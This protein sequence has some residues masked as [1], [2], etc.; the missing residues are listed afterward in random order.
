MG[1]NICFCVYVCVGESVILPKEAKKYSS[2]QPNALLKMTDGEK[3][4]SSRTETSSNLH[5]PFVGVLLL[6]QE[7][8]FLM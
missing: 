1:V 7:T 4:L 6:F 3:T 5:C 8:S 2:Q